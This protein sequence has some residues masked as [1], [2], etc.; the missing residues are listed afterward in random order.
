VRCRHHPFGLAEPGRPT[1]T[2][3]EG[4]SAGRPALVS[5]RGGLDEVVDPYAGVVPI[6]PTAVVMTDAVAR[7]LEP[8]VWYELVRVGAASG[9]CGGDR[10]WVERYLEIYESLA[11]AS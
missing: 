5:R 4:L 2:L 9:W 10:R 3:V 6:E 11:G 7:L 1:H 8:A